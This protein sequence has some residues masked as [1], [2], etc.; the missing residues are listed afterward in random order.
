VGI[1]ILFIDPLG[2]NVFDEMTKNYLEK[3]KSKDTVIDVVSF[4]GGPQHL[5]YYSYVAIVIPEILRVIK[6][7]EKE[8][9]DAVIIGCFYDPGLHEAREIAKKII[10]VAPCESSLHIASTL[11]EKFSIIVG[12]KKWVPLMMKNVVTY[13][14]RDKLVSF[15]SVELGV[16]DFHKD[17]NETKKRLLKAAREAVEEGAEV[18]INGCTA[19]VGFFEEMQRE[20]GIPVIDPVIASLKYAEFLVQLN[21]STGWWFSRKYTYEPPPEEELVKW[22]LKDLL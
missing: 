17:V 12:R 21:K 7:A 3:Y 1:K 13:G 19:L 8:N 9:Y 16:H 18:V 22:N 6:K 2:T 20:L 15:K 14:F 11:G 5:E 10:V 4:A